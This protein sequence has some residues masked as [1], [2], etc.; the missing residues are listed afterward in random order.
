MLSNSD[1]KNNNPED[2]FFDDLYSAFKLIRIPARRMINS[3][4]SKRGSINEIIVTNY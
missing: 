1:P 2:N 4:A 3:D